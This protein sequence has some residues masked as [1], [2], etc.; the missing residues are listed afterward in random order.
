M[1]QAFHHLTT[2]Q[3]RQR[4]VR[5]KLFGTA[6]RP[7]ISVLRSNKKFQV[8]VI[9]D[10]AGKTLFGMHSKSQQKVGD[11]LTKTQVSN[12]L[13]KAVAAELQKRKIAAAIFDRGQYPYLGRIR[14]FVQT[15]RAEG[16]TI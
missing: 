8:Q 1:S 15:V 7:R 16:I 12:A 3:I 2:D 10:G 13:A 14:E 9:D 11:G 6:K 4:R 5:A